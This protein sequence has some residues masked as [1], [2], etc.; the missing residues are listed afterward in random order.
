MG[1][2][3]YKENSKNLRIGTSPI[4]AVPSLVTV[5]PKMLFQHQQQQLLAARKKL[6]A[7]PVCCVAVIATV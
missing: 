4:D 7:M 3:A 6:P 5:Q 1:N 2:Y